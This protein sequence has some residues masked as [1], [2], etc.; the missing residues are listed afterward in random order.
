MKFRKKPVV[1]DAIQLPPKGNFDVDTFI[2][3]AEEHGLEYTSERDETIVI[4]TLEGKMTAQ[5]G[6]YIIKGV[7]G[8]FYPCKP[9]I[10]E[11]TYKI[12]Q[13][14]YDEVFKPRETSLWRLTE[15]QSNWYKKGPVSTVALLG[16]LGEAGEVLNECVATS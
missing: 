3:W 13:E 16:L 2:A 5:P 6:D 1:I 9:D 15:L 14:N 12:E 4:D 11:M 8:E 10:F 7:K